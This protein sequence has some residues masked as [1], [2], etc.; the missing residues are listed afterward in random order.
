MWNNQ[1]AIEIKVTH[2]VEFEKKEVLEKNNYTTYEFT[3]PK[4]MKSLIA[5]NRDF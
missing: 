5:E 2:A 1:L 3:V 4:S